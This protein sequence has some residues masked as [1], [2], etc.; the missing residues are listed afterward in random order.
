MNL[1][2][3]YK[4]LNQIEGRPWIIDQA[5]KLYGT[6]ECPGA[7]NNPTILK[8]AKEV[9]RW[10][11]DFYTK[12]S[13]P[14]CG[15][16]AAIV[17]Q[18]AKKEVVKNYLR[19]L[20][21]ANFGKVVGHAEASLGDVLTFVRKGG[22]HV[23]FYVAEDKDCYHVLGGNQSDSVSITRITKSRLYS[24]NRAEY[25]NQPKGVKKYF[26]AANGEV[27]QNEQ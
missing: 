21:W 9:G 16:F 17:C 5:L 20:S 10:E 24:V 13:I 27:S 19:A 23:A 22:G 2:A 14:W 3:K 1:P 15:L 18:R 26:I 12:D 4:W 11:A 6:L 25:R 8:W 7:K